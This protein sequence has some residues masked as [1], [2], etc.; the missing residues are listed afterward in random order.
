MNEYN[1]YLITDGTKYK[2]GV[3]RCIN[4]LIDRLEVKKA[5]TL[6]AYRKKNSRV[7]ALKFLKKITDRYSL[8]DGWIEI[9]DINPIKT[10]MLSI[11][12]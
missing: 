11:Y 8:K 2:L 6:I 12:E 5:I 4:G 9:S 7:D 10:D 3:C 1:I